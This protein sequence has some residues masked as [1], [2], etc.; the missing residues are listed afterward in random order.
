ML[1]DYVKYSE[2]H[3]DANL[4]TQK[5]EMKK[6]KNRSG[7]GWFALCVSM[8]SLIYIIDL[9]IYVYRSDQWEYLML[10]VMKLNRF[11]TLFYAWILQDKRSC[12]RITTI[13]HSECTFHA[14]NICK[15]ESFYSL[16]VCLF[17]LWCCIAK[18]MLMRSMCMISCGN[19]IIIC[20]TG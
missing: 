11:L 20:K 12:N 6:N 7:V 15:L 10:D 1:F 9:R 8:D 5:N 18:L 14:Q 4:C 2:Y 13:F 3:V 19:K 17:V 16:C